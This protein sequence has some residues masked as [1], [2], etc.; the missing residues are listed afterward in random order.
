VAHFGGRGE[1]VLDEVV[2]L[3]LDSCDVFTSMER[4]CYKAERWAAAMQL[5]EIAIAHVEGGQSRA[6]R[7]ADLYARRGNVGF[8][9]LWCQRERVRNRLS[10]ARIG[11]VWQF[12]GEIAEDYVRIGQSGPCT[13][14]GIVMRQRLLV[15][16]DGVAEALLCALIPGES[17]VEVQKICFYDVR[18]RIDK[19]RSRAA[20]EARLELGD[21]RTSDVVL[22]GEHPSCRGR[23]CRPKGCG[24]ILRRPG[25][26]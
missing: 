19:S 23:N 18:R 14:I 2:E 10:S 1:Q 3:L 15:Q 20:T 12:P 16:A 17:P 26:R 13:R 4:V 22:Y 8:L 11:R 24:R 6:Y 25:A 9:K 5:Y 7:L 21:D